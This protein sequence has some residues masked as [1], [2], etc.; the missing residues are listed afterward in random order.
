M[1][2]AL[3]TFSSYFPVLCGFIAPRTIKIYVVENV[4]E[5][6][7]RS[8]KIGSPEVRIYRAVPEIRAVANERAALGKVVEDYNGPYIVRKSF[9]Y[10]ENPRNYF[11]EDREIKW[12]LQ[13]LP[14]NVVKLVFPP[15]QPDIVRLAISNA[16]TKTRWHI[17]LNQ[18]RLSVKVGHRYAVTFGARADEP[19]DIAVAVSKAHVPWDGLGLY[20]VFSLTPQWQS[21]K[22]EFMATADD[23]NARIHFDV[24]GN[25]VSLDLSHVTL[26]SLP[27]SEPSNL[28]SIDILSATDSTL[29]GAEEWTIR[30]LDLT[31]RCAY[32]YWVTLIP[33]GKECAKTIPSP[34]N[35]RTY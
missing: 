4:Y 7:A 24:G 8:K 11:D 29:W 5:D 1:V 23:D 17:Q 6:N 2:V 27:E 34:V 19:R 16:D 33:W 26:R 31:A 22:A 13:V 3:S 28:A 14:G 32:F 30:Y 12:R 20:R 21:F 25:A 15:G 9:F 18:D 35:W 10:R